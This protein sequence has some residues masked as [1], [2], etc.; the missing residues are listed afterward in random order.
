MHWR[1]SSYAVRFVLIPAL[2]CPL[3]MGLLM[4]F[5]MRGNK[6]DQAPPGADQVITNTYSTPVEVTHESPKRNSLL[7]MLFMCLNWKVVAGLAVVA[8][9]VLV[10]APQFIW[11]ALPLLLV[12]ACPLSMLVM[13]WGMH[14]GQSPAQTAQ[15]GQPQ[16]EGRTRQEQIARLEAQLASTQAQLETLARETAET[17]R[18]G[19]LP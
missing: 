4:W 6:Q 5:L 14:R 3:G 7:T 10:V 12:A 13:M 11:A 8:V 1:N 19:E 16:S 2:A 15:M 18:A 17:A 9:F